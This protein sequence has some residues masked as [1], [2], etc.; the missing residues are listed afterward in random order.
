MPLRRS[1]RGRRNNGTIYE[2]GGELMSWL[3]IILLVAIVV[4]AI[5]FV[6]LRRNR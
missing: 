4:A 1:W 6:A 3:D 2:K 5:V